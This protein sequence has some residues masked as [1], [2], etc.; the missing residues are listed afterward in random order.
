MG[1]V[2]GVY[3]GFCPNCRGPVEEDRLA[4]GLPCRKCLPRPAGGDVDSIV[5]ALSA[6]GR[7]GGY[8]WIWR[9][10]KDLEEFERFFEERTG[11][12]LWS[13]QRS[14][15]KRLLRGES[16]AIIAP[17]GV[18]KTTLVSTYA[19]FTA[20][21]R[22]WRVL[23]LVPTENLVRQVSSRLEGLARANIYYYYSRLRP[24]AREEALERIGRGGPG[25]IVVTT[26]FLQRRFSLLASGGPFNLVVVDDVDSLLRNSRNVE[27]VLSL[28]GFS[29]D[30]VAAALRLVEARIQLYQALTLG[31]TRIEGLQKKVAELEDEVRRGLS[32]LARV[33][34]L[35]IASATGRPRGYKH[36][37]FRE[38]LGFEVGGGSDYLRNILDAYRIC[39]DPLACLRD[40]AL[41]LG[42]G[43]IVFVSQRLGKEWARRAAE[44]LEESG[45]RVAL[46]LTGSRRPV[47]EFASSKAKV[48]VGV[49][50]RYGVIVRGLDL[51]ERAKYALFLTAPGLRLRASEALLNP[52]RLLRL[53]DY[54]SSRGEDWA[55]DYYERIARALDKVRDP[56]ILVAAAK[57]SFKAEGWLAEAASLLLEA[58]STAGDWAVGEARKSGGVLRVGS[59]VVDSQGYVTVPDALTYLQASGRTSRLYKGVMT[60]GV[61]VVFD[62]NEAYVEALWER[63]RWVSGT[64][65]KELGKVDLE[66]AKRKVEDSRRGRGKK[67]NVKTVLLV[68]ESPT[69][70]R[71]IAWF[72]GRPGKRRV[73]RL[74]VY[75][76]SVA[77][78][79]AGVVYILNVT[80]TRGHVTDLAVDAPDTRYG[81]K[82]VNSTL[83]PIY[84]TIRRCLE[85]GWQFVAESSVCVRC[86]SPRIID[87]MSVVDLLRKLAVEVDEVVVATDPDREGEK[88]AWDVMLAI[89]PYNQ[90][91]KRGRFHEVTPK[92]VLEALRGAG[93]FALSL[94]KAQ[95]ARRIVDRWIGF[96]LSSHLWTVYGK[97]WLGAGRVQTPVLGWIVDAYKKWKDAR[98]Y[99]AI[100][101]LESGGRLSIFAS[102]REEAEDVARARD[103]EVTSVEAYW[104]ER[105]PPPPFTTDTLLYEASTRLG[106]NATIAMRVAQ[107]LFEWGLITYH[108]TDSTRV[109]SA[110]VAVARTWL[111]KA[112]LASLFRPR[113]WGE[114][115]AHEAIRPT[116]PLDSRELER[117]V[118]DGSIRIA[119]KLTRLHLAVYDMIFRRFVASQMAPGKVLVVRASL[120]VGGKR[121]EVEGIA[122]AK[123]GFV[124]V[125]PPQTSEWLSRLKPGVRLAVEDSRVVRGSRER[126]LKSGDVIR[127]MKEHG[128]GRPSTY[129]KAIEANM[130]HG[131]VIES[132]KRRFLIPTRLGREVYVYLSTRFPE[133]ISVETS[134]RLEEE[135]D[136]IERSGRGV[137]SMLQRAWALIEGKLEEASATASIGGEAEART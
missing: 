44:V 126:L 130:R 108:R 9:L 99:Y 113:Y 81:V 132:K 47:E 112:G 26:G 84:G 6:R 78:E 21:K 80:A 135:L 23:Y 133:L 119:G 74:T 4:K 134:R 27:R 60:F 128:I 17:T 127:L 51:P 98:G 30:L 57:G 42:D 46:A 65:F 96:S 5:R 100:L 79:E 18:G 10:E 54:A 59:F 55:R 8:Y 2:K 41:E 97:P 120:S 82:V 29:E 83:K 66:E 94:V 115:G 105:Q 7:L 64:S 116:R 93:P 50:S 118:L 91:V 73:G 25:I 106:V 33:G 110:G 34:Q 49:A 69:K 39:R 11:L 75:E 90:N 131:Y 3:R 48:L 121:V 37:V 136:A 15:A 77:D 12:R 123:G 62:F 13:A 111:E 103:V 114:G 137:Y 89:K 107:D 20:E 53:L 52:R 104:E 87:S 76:A 36:L 14:W 124:E 1:A 38:L 63:L 28:L 88:I 92:A 24:S 70:A 43:V 101:R 95:E 109:S 67:V 56:T 58:S 35:V 122:G 85:C 117:A 86:G 45:L 129:A 125:Y 72:W 32:T 19:S 61:S 31:S 16:L 40:L 68:V 71:T 102:E 22:G